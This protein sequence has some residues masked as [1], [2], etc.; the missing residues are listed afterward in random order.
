MGLMLRSSVNISRNLRALKKVITL[1]TTLTAATNTKMTKKR[2]MCQPA[3][4]KDFSEL[5]SKNLLLL[6]D[7]FQHAILWLRSHY[8]IFMI[9]GEI[10]SSLDRAIGSTHT[11]KM[12]LG[13]STN[14]GAKLWTQGETFYTYSHWSTD[15]TQC[16]PRVSYKTSKNGLRLISNHAKSKFCQ[17][18]TLI[19]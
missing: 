7:L 9:T 8:Q 15:R 10:L 13:S 5:I 17:V 19:D 18:F 2:N 3:S 1:G 14:L 12:A 16:W 4:I 6:S 11:Q